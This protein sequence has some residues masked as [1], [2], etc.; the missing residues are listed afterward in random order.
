[1]PLITCP[2]CKKKVSSTA[3]SCPHCGASVAG[4]REAQIQGTDALVLIGSCVAGLFLGVLLSN[5]ASEDQINLRIF[6]GFAG[7]IAPPTGALYWSARKLK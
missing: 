7:L 1:M 5:F 6:L 3:A 2:E 4:K